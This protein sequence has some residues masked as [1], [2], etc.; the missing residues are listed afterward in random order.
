MENQ[1]VI[2]MF[3]NFFSGIRI[4]N[5]FAAFRQI[6]FETLL[7]IHFTKP[8]GD[9]HE[10][11]RLIAPYCPGIRFDRVCNPVKATARYCRQHP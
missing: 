8:L 10:I 3:F 7:N 11:M 1:V 5:R 9:G 2:K 6:D 4:C